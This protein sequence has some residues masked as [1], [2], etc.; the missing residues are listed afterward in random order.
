MSLNQIDILYATIMNMLLE[1]GFKKK[2]TI[3]IPMTDTCECILFYDVKLLGYNEIL[4][5]QNSQKRLMGLFKI[6]DVNTKI[7]PAIEYYHYNP[8]LRACDIKYGGYLISCKPI[9]TKKGLFSCFE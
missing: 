3:F 8:W 1:K 7:Y 9:R 4:Y 5:N 6:N 2:L